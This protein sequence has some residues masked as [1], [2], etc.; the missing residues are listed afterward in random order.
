MYDVLDMIKYFKLKH[1]VNLNA[2]S[3][4]IIAIIIIIIII[5][6]IITI[7]VIIIIMLLLLLFSAG[8]LCFIQVH[9][10][11]ESNFLRRLE[12]ALVAELSIYEKV[13]SLGGTTLP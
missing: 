7:I 4:I 12:E 11:R 2:F 10:T 3:S 8:K 13:A 5:I 1:N 9:L 6:T